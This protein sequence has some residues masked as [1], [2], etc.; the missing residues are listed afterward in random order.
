MR[1]YLEI[2]LSGAQS[3]ARTWRVR[4][5]PV[6]LPQAP[7]TVHAAL[8]SYGTKFTLCISLFVNPDPFA[9]PAIYYPYRGFVYLFVMRIFKS[10]SPSA[11]WWRPV[12]IPLEINFG[13][14]FLTRA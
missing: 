9:I 13:M 8:M 3:R 6:A 1:G 5:P 2:G 14:W 7:A 11:N 10:R 12:V 4:F